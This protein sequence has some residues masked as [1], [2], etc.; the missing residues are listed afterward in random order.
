M[1]KKQI[2]DYEYLCHER[3]SG[4]LLTSDGIRFI[5][6][7]CMDNYASR[8]C[9]FIDFVLQQYVKEGVFELDDER[10]G[11]LVTLK[12]GSAVDAVQELGSGIRNM[13]CEFQQYLY[14][15]AA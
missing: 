6:E 4:R 3:N 7:A 10:I 15:K 5:C 1:A 11:E 9:A 8:Q 12:Y 2:E 13:F 14:Q